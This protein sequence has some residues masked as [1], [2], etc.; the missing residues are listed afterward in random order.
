MSG[1]DWACLDATG[2]DWACLGVTE[3]D[4][5]EMPLGVTSRVDQSQRYLFVHLLKN[6]YDFH[7]YFG[8]TFNQ[9]HAVL[10]R[11]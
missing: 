4:E 1:R 10:A 5:N 7:I 3:H 11:T 8:T 9:I 6:A 2:R